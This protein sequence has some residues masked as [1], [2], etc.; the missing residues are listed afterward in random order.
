MHPL[1]DRTMPPAA[2]PGRR[3]RGSVVSRGDRRVVVAGTG[4]LSHHLQ[5]KDF[6]FVNP[7]WTRSFST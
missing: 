3:A 1:A 2:R 6:G 7:E 5:G 4:G